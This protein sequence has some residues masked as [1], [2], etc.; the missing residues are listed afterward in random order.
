VG[1]HTA[2]LLGLHSNF[3]WRCVAIAAIASNIPDWDGLLFLIDHQLF[4]RGHRVWG[5]NV[6]A[7]AIQS[8]L[9][10]VL[11]WRLDFLGKMRRRI[12]NLLPKGTPNDQNC[13]KLWVLIAVLYG[14]QI[15]HL[16][17]DAVVSGG[18]NLSDWAVKP[19]WPIS[20]FDL[21]YPM[22]RWGDVGP[23]IIL[24]TGIIGLAKLK[25]HIRWITATTLAA[26][27]IY[28]AVQGFVF[29]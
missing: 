12:E 21:I 22:I 10:G 20:N 28:L 23:T 11:Q 27:C 5:H 1:V 16:F 26:L 15:L 24:F 4:D 6:F 25:R 18:K 19:F 13:D 29:S 8:L 17:C 2:L 14:F 3:G 7:I 9:I